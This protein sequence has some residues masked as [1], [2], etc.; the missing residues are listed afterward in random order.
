M[1]AYGRYLRLRVCV[2]VAVSLLLLSGACDDPEAPDPVSIVSP[3][4]GTAVGGGQDV[5]FVASVT[6]LEG[7]LDSACWDFGDG[8]GGSGLTTVH[9]YTRAGDYTVVFSATSEYDE[10]VSASVAV[11]VTSSRFRKLDAFGEPL[12]DNASMW[13]SVRDTTSGL[14]W[15]VK[16]N[17]DGEPHYENPSDADNTYTWHDA[18]PLTNGGDAGA[19]GDGTDTEDFISGLNAAACGGFTSWRLPTCDELAKL[20]DPD[21]FN[22]AID[23]FYFPNTVSWYYWSSTTYEDFTYA[24]CHIYFM[25]TPTAAR[26]VAYPVAYNHYGMKDLTY[27]ARAVTDREPLQLWQG[28]ETVTVEYDG[29]ATTVALSG[30]HATT[31]K[32]KQA[33]VL[34]DI[35]QESSIVDDPENYYYVFYAT[36]GYSLETALLHED[37]YTGFPPWND[38][39]RGYVY[40]TNSELY[41]LMVGWEDGTIGGRV[42][43]CYDVKWMNGGS[44]QLRDH[45]IEYE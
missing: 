5:F 25:G 39:Q 45:D 40:Q 22:P 42:H 3:R 38:M 16:Q 36:D 29:R 26:D 18:D 21:R 20:Q 34:S 41:G 9:A 12:A 23:T 35:I 30:L 17:R 13:Y 44:I 7:E 24:A 28:D 1:A 4:P 31:F 37:F 43:H 11:W 33:M 19:A 8:T 2:P 32:G 15:E 14:V 6:G 27:H 10:Q